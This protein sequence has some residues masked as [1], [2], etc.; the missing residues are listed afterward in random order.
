MA[1]ILPIFYWRQKCR[2]AS[3]CA[4]TLVICL[5]RR[6]QRFVLGKQPDGG[7]CEQLRIDNYSTRRHSAISAQARAEFALECEIFPQN[8][9]K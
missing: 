6:C 4:H 9:L 5:F 2:A 8:P 7:L 3:T 1:T